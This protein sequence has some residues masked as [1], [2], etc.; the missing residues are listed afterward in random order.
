MERL[1]CRRI[2]WHAT[3]SR[4]TS[5]VSLKK[6][7][8]VVLL[9]LGLDSYPKSCTRDQFQSP[10][11]TTGVFELISV[12][13][14]ST[15]KFRKHVFCLVRNE[16]EGHGC[17]W[18]IFLFFSFLYFSFLFFSNHLTYRTFQ[19]SIEISGKISV[20]FSTLDRP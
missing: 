5:H 15:L 10:L 8:M 20:D 19:K 9:L 6:L 7:A 12:G 1:R 11:K 13:F 2:V 16:E 4:S 3:G 18:G 14:G 17:D